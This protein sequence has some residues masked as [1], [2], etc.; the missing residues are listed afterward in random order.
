MGCGSSCRTQNT[1]IPIDCS[2][3]SDEKSIYDTRK[4]LSELIVVQTAFLLPE[5]SREPPWDQ[6]TCNL[7]NRLGQKLDKK[8][9]FDIEET[10]YNEDITAV[11]RTM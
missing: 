2:T 4:L 7:Y 9:T 3:V 11:S 8:L 5:H 1:N 10:E 6:R